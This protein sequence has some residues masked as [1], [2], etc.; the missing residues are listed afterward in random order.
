VHGGRLQRRRQLER[1]RAG[2]G[3]NGVQGRLHHRPEIDDPDVQAQLA[4]D[5][6]GD[7]EQVLDELALHAR[8]ALDGLQGTAGGDAVEARGAQGHRPA[9]HRV[10]RRAQLVRQGRQELVL[11]PVGGLGLRARPLGRRQELGVA[12]R[13]RGVVGQLA[14]DHLVVVGERLPSPVVDAEQALELGADDDRHHHD[15]DDL[16]A[17]DGGQVLVV[18]REAGIAGGVVAPYRLAGGEH[19]SAGAAPRRHHRRRVCLLVVPDAVTKHHGAGV[20]LAQGDCRE[21][22]AAQLPRP[23]RDHLEDRVQLER[24]DDRASELAEQGCPPE[25]AVRILAPLT[26]GTAA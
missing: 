4:V 15:R 23:R 26:E 9:E 11:H 25:L 13:D 7:V 17:G 10:Q 16:L 1:L 19:E 3:P 6:P 8:V 22:A 14:Q 12:D 18:P 24:G 20:W 5:D 21:V 2:G